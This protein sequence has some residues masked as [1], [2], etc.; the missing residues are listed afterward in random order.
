VCAVDK[1]ITY[2]HLCPKTPY[3]IKHPQQETASYAF[4]YTC[5]TAGTHPREPTDCGANPKFAMGLPEPKN[6]RDRTRVRVLTKKPPRDRD[7]FL[8]TR[9]GV[10]T[11]SA[12]KVL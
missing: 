2:D 11:D 7:S 6:H 8:Y 12:E 3:S 5:D 10:L 4:V 9:V 1:N